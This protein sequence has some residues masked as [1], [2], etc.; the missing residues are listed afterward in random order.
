MPKRKANKKATYYKVP[1]YVKAPQ[2]CGG[3]NSPHTLQKGQTYKAIG[4]VRIRNR[5]Y[6]IIQVGDDEFTWGKERFE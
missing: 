5:D 6:Y 3:F 1:V 2:G 4:E